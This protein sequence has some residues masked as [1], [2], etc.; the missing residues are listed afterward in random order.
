MR[1][2]ALAQTTGVPLATVKLYQREGLLMPG[3]LLNKTQADYSDEHVARV[4]LISILTSLPGY[5]YALLRQLFGIAEDSDMAV[6]QRV[7]VAM[8][9]LPSGRAVKVRSE[10][11]HEVASSLN[12]PLGSDQASMADLESALTA[13]ELVGLPC[14]TERLAGYWQHMRAIAMLE[15][16]GMS[17]QSASAD[18]VLYALVGT[19]VYEPV[20]LALRRLA[21]QQLFM[22]Q[23]TPDS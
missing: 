14:S 13:A 19:A 20:I 11:A 8:Q 4:R 16:A 21:H 5:S 9:R 10:S 6:P 7:A 22:G 3:R 18:A 17:K 23:S 12:V 1:I 2:S 15:V